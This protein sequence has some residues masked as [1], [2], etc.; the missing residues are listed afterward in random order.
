MPKHPQP[1]LVAELL[2]DA[3]RQGPPPQGDHFKL[4]MSGYPL[5]PKG[6][7]RTSSWRRRGGG[8]RVST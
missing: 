8:G 1:L 2:S 6:L 4:Y 7:W 5:P 3:V